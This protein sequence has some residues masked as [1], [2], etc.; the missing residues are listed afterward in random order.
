[1]QEASSRGCR[2]QRATGHAGPQPNAGPGGRGRGGQRS[3]ASP[4]GPVRC[5]RTMVF[6]FHFP[7]DPCLGVQLGEPGPGP[8]ALGRW[9]TWHHGHLALAKACPPAPTATAGPPEPVTQCQ[10]HGGRTVKA[11]P[12]SESSRAWRCLG[13]MTWAGAMLSP[14]CPAHPVAYPPG[15]DFTLRTGSQVCCATGPRRGH[16]LPSQLGWRHWAESSV[17]LKSPYPLVWWQMCAPEAKVG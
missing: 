5:P 9:L 2:E 14:W 1:M 16:G 7:P 15:L 12:T 4:L 6:R 13:R 17:G 3:P 8:M 10:A 11:E